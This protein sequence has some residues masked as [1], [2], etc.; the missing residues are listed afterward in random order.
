[1]SSSPETR[2]A[3]RAGEITRPRST[4]AREGEGSNISAGATPL[5]ITTA[6]DFAYP[7]SVSFTSSTHQLPLRVVERDPEIHSA[8]RII[9]SVTAAFLVGQ[10]DE[11]P[12]KTAET[13]PAPR[14][15]EQL[16]TPRGSSR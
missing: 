16:A 12:P 15:L 10:G 14:A 11:R 7:W 3:G 8:C 5:S 9:S 1:V 2:G 13:A 6:R 4:R